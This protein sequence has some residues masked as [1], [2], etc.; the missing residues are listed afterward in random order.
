MVA[1]EAVMPWSRAGDAPLIM[2]SS[3]MVLSSMKGGLVGAG[4]CSSPA[5]ISS[6][7]DM[8]GRRDEASCVHNSAT[9]TTLIIS[10]L[11]LMVC[12]SCSIRLGSMSSS[13]FL[14]W[15]CF[16]ALFIHKF[17]QISHIPHYFNSPRFELQITTY[18]SYQ[19]VWFFTPIVLY[20][21]DDFQQNHAKAINVYFLCQLAMC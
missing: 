21:C 2:A 6:A 14:C 1:T 10:F 13:T 18:N 15:K 4:S 19:A 16:Q 20:A 12:W 8:D 11:A 7:I 17:S 3:S 9:W 5:S